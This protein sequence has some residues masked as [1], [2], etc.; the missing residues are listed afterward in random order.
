MKL[1]Y[2][3]FTKQD[4][5]EFFPFGKTKLNQLLKAKAL[6]VVKV[7]RH[8]IT[9]EKELNDWFHKHKGTEIRF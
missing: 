8:Y 3:T 4:L 6:P 2:T 5:L 9:N 1:D 7:G